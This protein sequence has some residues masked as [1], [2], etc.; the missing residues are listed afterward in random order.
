MEHY[1]GLHS[2]GLQPCPQ[3]LHLGGS[4]CGGKLSSL[5]RYDYDYGRKKVL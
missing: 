1:Q 5:L 3:I 4:Q 2:N